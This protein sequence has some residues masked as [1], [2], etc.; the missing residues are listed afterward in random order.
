MMDAQSATQSLRRWLLV[1]PLIWAPR[2]VDVRSW[3]PALDG[4]SGAVRPNRLS[5]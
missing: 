2:R 3:V 1:T 5:A 4:E